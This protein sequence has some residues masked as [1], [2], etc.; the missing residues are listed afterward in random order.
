MAIRA[1]E[2]LRGRHPPPE[3]INPV[4]TEEGVLHL[5]DSTPANKM[6]ALQRFHDFRI[7]N[8]DAKPL[9]FMSRNCALQH[10]LKHILSL[11]RFTV[12]DYNPERIVNNAFCSI[13]NVNMNPF[14]LRAIC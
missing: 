2:E 8:L 4:D 12:E 11:K 5:N 9:S 3:D 13:I 1:K 7:G 6:L 10:R 14:F